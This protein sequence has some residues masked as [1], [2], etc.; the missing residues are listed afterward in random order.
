LRKLKNTFGLLRLIY[1]NTSSEGQNKMKIVLFYK[2]SDFT[3]KN[4]E[5]IDIIS[6]FKIQKTMGN[7][8]VIKYINKSSIL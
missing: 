6:R 7:R 3:G 1:D 5:L 4:R 2:I 8:I